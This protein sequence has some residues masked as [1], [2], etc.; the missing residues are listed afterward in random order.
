MEEKKEVV[1]LALPD[2]LLFEVFAFASTYDLEQYVD[3]F[4]DAKTPDLRLARVLTKF[5]GLSHKN[6]T[7]GARRIAYRI[8][9]RAIEGNHLELLMI[10]L[11]SGPP[12]PAYKINME[13]QAIGWLFDDIA[14]SG[15]IEML[16]RVVKFFPQQCAGSGGRLVR[17][18]TD[19]DRPQV[20]RWLLDNC[21]LL[22][23]KDWRVACGYADMAHMIQRRAFA[24]LGEVLPRMSKKRALDLFVD[25]KACPRS[26]SATDIGEALTARMVAIVREP[27]ELSACIFC[28]SVVG[29]A[30]RKNHVRTTKHARALHEFL[31]KVPEAGAIREAV[32][33]VLAV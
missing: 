30:S 15:R 8:R 31:K 9:E 27:F 4:L 32:N 24:V 12:I 21:A 10:S 11:S 26:R 18:A 23:E 2:D 14:A 19:W 29:M 6:K 7:E 22:G 33:T 5:A 1:Q 20:V 25:D 13:N 3:A 17:T 28:G 16:Q